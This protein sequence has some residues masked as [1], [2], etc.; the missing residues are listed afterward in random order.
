MKVLIIEDEQIAAS[1][2]VE[3][4]RDFDRNIEVVRILD[5]VASSIEF[6]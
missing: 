2:L 4:L 3:M 1:R 6:F 5:S